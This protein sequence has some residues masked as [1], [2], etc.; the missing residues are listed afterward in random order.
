M[1]YVTALLGLWALGVSLTYWWGRVLLP[2]IGLVAP[3]Y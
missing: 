3:G 2:E 1:R